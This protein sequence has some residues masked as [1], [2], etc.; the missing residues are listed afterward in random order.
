MDAERA[1]LRATALE[2]V[3]AE[4]TSPNIADVLS[5]ASEAQSGDS[6]GLI[7]IKRRELVFVGTN[8]WWMDVFQSAHS[9]QT[10]GLES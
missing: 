7:D 4:D 10:K 6:T 2:V 1:L 8:L 3:V 9:L 5:K